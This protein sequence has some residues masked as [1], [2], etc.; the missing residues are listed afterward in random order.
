M[1]SRIYCTNPQ[2]GELHF[3]LLLRGKP[4]YL[5]CQPYRRQVYQFYARPM[6]LDDALSYAKSKGSDQISKTIS[7]LPGA[8][9]YIESEYGI[10]VLKRTAKRQNIAA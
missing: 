6:L 1:M 2:H 3:Y 4:Y 5:F 7:R 9:H 8:I 10:A